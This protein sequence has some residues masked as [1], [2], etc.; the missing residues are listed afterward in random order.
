LKAVFQV[1]KSFIVERVNKLALLNTGNLY[2]ITK[3]QQHPFP[4]II[5]KPLAK[6]VK[7]IGNT[8]RRYI[9][10]ALSLEAI[11]KYRTRNIH[12]GRAGNQM[13]QN[14]IGIN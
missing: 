6:Y 5:G 7:N 9:S 11:L 14:N 13:V 12:I 3:S 4:F 10:I 2:K 8:V 1:I